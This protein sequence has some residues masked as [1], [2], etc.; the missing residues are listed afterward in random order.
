LDE[1]LNRAEKYFRKK[2]K[3][4]GGEKERETEM[5]GREREK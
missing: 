2:G 3:W 5:R 1:K 4:K